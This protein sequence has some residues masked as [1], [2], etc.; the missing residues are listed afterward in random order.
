MP[1]IEATVK[2]AAKQLDESL[3]EL[4][5]EINVSATKNSE[6]VNFVSNKL[7]ELSS[8][9]EKSQESSQKLGGKILWLNIVLTFATVIAAIATAKVAF[10]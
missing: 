2:I 10:G 1:N 9:I 5:H 4:R 8:N 7:S 6:A 3:K